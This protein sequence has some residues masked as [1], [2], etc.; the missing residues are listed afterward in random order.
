MKNILTITNRQSF[1]EW[2]EKYSQTEQEC[3]LIVKRG[4]PSEQDIFYY[5]DAVEEALCF[6]WVDST[7][8]K[9]DGQ[10]WQRFSPRRKN[11]NWTALN[12]ARVRRLESL[13]LMTEQGRAALLEPMVSL[14]G[15]VIECLKVA[16]VWEVFSNFPKLYQEIRISNIVFYRNRQPE[17]YEKMLDKLISETEKGKLYGEWNDYGRLQ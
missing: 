1:R 16:G 5:I 6:G 2:L 9:V 10:T 13:G 15:E 12:K 8:K 7:L 14:D 11:S 3:W 4:K 17:T